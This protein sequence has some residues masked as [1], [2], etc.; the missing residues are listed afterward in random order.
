MVN[1]STWLLQNANVIFK[2]FWNN[3]LTFKIQG[4]PCYLGR[5]V[6]IKIIHEYKK[7][8]AVVWFCLF[9]VEALF[10][11]QSLCLFFP[12]SK[13]SS[14]YPHSGGQGLTIYVSL[15]QTWSRQ[16]VSGQWRLHSYKVKHCLK[17]KQ[18][19]IPNL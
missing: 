6:E 17:T 15:W 3:S 8:K 9:Q 1:I 14:T 5:Y 18:N 12:T 4:E 19:K 13:N 11:R 2:P 7:Y 16:Q 10:K